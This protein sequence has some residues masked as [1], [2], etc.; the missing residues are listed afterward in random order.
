MEQVIIN[1]LIGL[2]GIAAGVG[3]SHLTLLKRVNAALVSQA[4]TD[5]QL[6][7]LFNKQS[8]LATENNSTMK[9]VRRILTNI[10]TVVRQNTILIERNT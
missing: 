6:T 2:L 7:T 4:R 9:L 8:E 3:I 1:V 5:E 10:E